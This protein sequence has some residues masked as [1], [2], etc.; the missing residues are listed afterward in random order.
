MSKGRCANL[1][2][3]SFRL[4]YRSKWSGTEGSHSYTITDVEHLVV[5]NARGT[6][7]TTQDMRD[8]HLV[9][10]DDGREVVCREEVRLNQD[11]IR[12]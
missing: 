7:L 10:V 4:A 3:S 1:G 9:I 2:G 12:W 11:R 8:A 5:G 6:Y